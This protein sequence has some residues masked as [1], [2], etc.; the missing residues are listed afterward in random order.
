M[1]NTIFIFPA[2]TSPLPAITSSLLRSYTPMPNSN[3]A[4]PKTELLLFPPNPALP[5][6]FLMPANDNSIL[7]VAR[8]KI[9]SH[10]SLLFISHPKFNLSENSFVFTLKIY[11]ASLHTFHTSPSRTCCHQGPLIPSLT[12]CGLLAIEQPE[13]CHYNVSPTGTLC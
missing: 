9:L 8:T 3:S 1:T 13:W 11:P 12:P 7:P 5:T 6:L 4:W 2:L 10:L